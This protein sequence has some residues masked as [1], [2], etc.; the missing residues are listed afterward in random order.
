MYTYIYIFRER[1][2]EGAG[3]RATSVRSVRSPSEM[4]CRGT[5]LISNNPPPG[6]Y[7]RPYGGLRG[8]QG[9]GCS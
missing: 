7:S 6:P 5:L 4:A 2:G 8:E 1:E 3:T 9:G